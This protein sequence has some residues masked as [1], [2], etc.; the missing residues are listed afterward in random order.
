[1]I[2]R[3]TILRQVRNNCDISDARHSGL[4]SICGLAL[5]LRDLYKWDNQLPPWEER[6]ATEVLDWIGAKEQRWEDIAEQ[7][8][9]EIALSGKKYDPFD[10]AGINAVLEPDGLYYGAGY[11]HSMKPTFFLAPI[12]E[13]RTVDGCAVHIL[14]LELARDLLTLPAMTQDDGI[15]FR[16]ESA[17]QFLWDQIAYIKKSGRPALTVALENCGLKRHDPDDIRRSLDKILAVQ[18]DS[19]IYHEL[20]EIRDTVFETDVWREVIAS[21]TRTPIELLA[22]NV[23]DLLADTNEYG[24]LHRVIEKKNLAALSFYVAFQDGLQR[25]LFP[26]L[27]TAFDEFI[28]A[29]S[30]SIIEQSV[31]VGFNRAKQYART[32]TA[33]FQEAK[34]K[35]DLNLA[36]D[37]IDRNLLA[38]LL[39]T[40]KPTVEN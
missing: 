1:M 26:E 23:K 10:T 28:V 4:Y 22:R 2:D 18:M 17:K 33:I 8:Y 12:E 16:K 38:P 9:D 40:R 3:N 21:F 11:A 29:H 7:D 5:R 30:W 27:K 15:L 14:G 20:G 13:N 37:L 31:S 35:K 6:D 39:T 24:S 25:E 36:R 34:Q 19:Y 32:I